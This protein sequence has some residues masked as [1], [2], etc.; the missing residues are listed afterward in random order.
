MALPWNV[1]RAAAQTPSFLFR[2]SRPCRQ[3][4]R[5]LQSREMKGRGYCQT[6]MV[7]AESS[8]LRNEGLLVGGQQAV[9]HCETVHSR[10][11]SAASTTAEPEAD[12]DKH[13]DLSASPSTD[14][15]GGRSNNGQHSTGQRVSST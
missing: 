1:N 12:G 10:V 6:L 11:T 9:Y 5:G 8:V 4:A 13:H 15:S 3:A 14:Q 2:A 7:V